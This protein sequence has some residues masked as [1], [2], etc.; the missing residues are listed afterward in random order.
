MSTTKKQTSSIDEFFHE[1][2]FRFVKTSIQ[3]LSYLQISVI[4]A[5]LCF[6]YIL[7]ILLTNTYYV[8][9]MNRTSLGYNWDRDGRFISSQLMHLLSFQ[10]EVVYSG[11][12]YNTL[13]SSL[14]LAFTGFLL[15]YTIGMRHKTF[16]FLGSLLLLT[17]PFILEIL[18]YK[19]D[20]LPISCS[21]F[22]AVLP[23]IFFNSTW[24]FALATTLSVYFLF[25]FYQTSA[26]SY[27][28]ILCFFSIKHIWLSEYKKTIINGII[29]FL[30]FVIGFWWH[31]YKIKQLGLQ[32]VDD[33]RASFIFKD[34]NFTQLLNERFNGFKE[35][36]FALYTNDYWIVIKVLIIA[37]LYSI[38]C[39]CWRIDW[40]KERILQILM[41]FCF[42][43]IAILF[44]IGINLFVY[45]YRWHPRSLIGYA[46]FTYIIL[47]ILYQLPKK[48]YWIA[49]VATAPLIYY[50]FLIS[51]QLGIFIKNQEELSD[52]VI[53]QIAT[54]TL[55]YNQLKLI[56][57]GEIQYAER[58][59]TVHY[60]TF[61][62]IYK[63]APK[64][65]KYFHY[66]GM[67]RLNKFGVF[68][69]EYIHSN[70][71]DQVLED[72]KTFPVIQSNT[73]YELRIQE[74]YAVINFK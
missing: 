67:V 35:L 57:D 55:K 38:I 36:L 48:Q 19:F 3:K 2:C 61:P 68:S 66:W 63:L 18:W 13:I 74:P 58:N 28:I 29:G 39:F 53:D 73:I 6:L 9:D 5:I 49:I 7:P 54:E 31:A 30:A 56:I 8:D 43:G 16:L 4:V 25:G 65:E 59:N 72:A 70:H 60:E 40:R 21:L 51:S 34:I 45:E 22:C 62:I 14:L 32:I 27:S 12:P 52:F 37:I 26:F 1:K 44:S 15:S 41:T 64:Y 24:R 71:R 47:F 33:Q 20:S 69:D 50:S 42:V 46:F 10:N 11:F 23:F 17:C